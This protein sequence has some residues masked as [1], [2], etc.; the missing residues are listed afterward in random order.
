MNETNGFSET[1]DRYKVHPVAS[2]FPMMDDDAFDGLKASIETRGQ[3][4][5]IVVQ[6]DVLLDGRNRLRACLELRRE[7]KIEQYSGTLVPGEYIFQLNY[8]RRDLT[9]A[10]RLDISF[11]ADPLI[12][13]EAKSRQQTAGARGVEGGRGH[14]KTLPMKSSEGFVLETEGESKAKK[15]HAGD[16]RKKLAD[17]AGV[18]EHKAQ[19]YLNVKAD[20]P[21]LLEDVKKGKMPLAQA[22]KVAAARRPRK[23]Q[24]RG[25]NYNLQEEVSAAFYAVLRRFNKCPSERRTEFKVKLLKVLDFSLT[26]NVD[27]GAVMVSI[28]TEKQIA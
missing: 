17:K 27:P 15:S 28:R 9:D 12:K 21:E 24:A 20:A 18:S 16:T 22:A 3:I 8:E 7:P 13:A 10:Q 6:G 11:K 14:Q 19:Q 2:L 4:V 26:L 23:P 1:I 5:P 25:K